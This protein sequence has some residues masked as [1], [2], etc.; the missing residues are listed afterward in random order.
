MGEARVLFVTTS[1]PSSPVDRAGPFVHALARALVRCGVRVRVIAP[2]HGGARGVQHMDGVEIRRFQFLPR[3]WQTL[4]M[5]FGGVP[6]ALR[7]APARLLQLPLMIGAAAAL[8]LRDASD[9]DVLHAHWL[10]NL[11]PLVPAG[12]LRRRPRLVTLWGSDVEWY[13]RSPAVQPAFRS[14]LRGADGVVAIN[15]HMRALFGGS[16][17]RGAELRLIPSGVDTD[18]FRPRERAA[19]RARYGIADDACGIVFAGSL[20][21]RK[22]AD[23]AID[24]LAGRSVPATAHLLLVGEGPEHERLEALARDRGVSSRVHFLGE[25]SLAEVAEVMSAA[26]AFVLPSHYEGRPNVVLEAQASGLAVVASDIPGCRDLI[27]PG[28]TGLLVPAGD[29]GALGDAFADVATDAS[30]RHRLG[31]NARRAIRD[32]GL[33]WEACARR[34]ADFYSD[35]IGARSPRPIR[36]SHAGS[37]RG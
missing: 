10:P 11:L 7:N 25:R 18:L 9:S 15:E 36:A 26:D 30:L 17:G 31:E 13:E 5:G 16:L 28:E 20:I 37:T 29:A 27:E 24:A 1:Y 8:A 14:L 35:L 32:G 12:W 23:V 6:A 21:P 22:G 19:L 33:T 2:A 4:T 3:R 34:Y